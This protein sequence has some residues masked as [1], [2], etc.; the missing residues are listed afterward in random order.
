MGKIQRAL[1]SVSDK[2]GIV[3]FCRGLS[4]LGIDL[5]STGGTASLLRQN[6]VP[7]R[8]VSEVTGFPEM[9]DGRVKTVH[10]KIHGGILALRDNP[11]HLSQMKAHGIGPIDLVIVNLY[12]FEAT[13]AKGASFEEIVEQID[14]GGPSMVRAAAK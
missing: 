4:E 14:I 11:E 12:P 6:N 7:V 8:D 13:V 3:E 5:V 1:V 10:P 2:K 9:M